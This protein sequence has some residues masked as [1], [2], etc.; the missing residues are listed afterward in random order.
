M[1]KGDFKTI[2]LPGKWT[3]ESV[4]IYAQFLGAGAF[5]KCYKYGESVYSYVKDGKRES[6]YSKQAIAGLRNLKN[7]HIPDIENLNNLENFD[8]QVY[9]SKFYNDL[10]N[11]SIN[12]WNQAKILKK[13]WRNHEIGL[14]ETGYT[15][16]LILINE[17]KNAGINENIINA[18]DEINTA[19]HDYG[20]DYYMEFPTRNLKVD[21]SG[22]LILLDIIFNQRAIR[23]RPKWN[24]S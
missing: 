6:D 7:C 19:C 1:K 20:E 21:E 12:A 2:E 14:H 10:T 23:E 16:N 5:A 8:G 17:F 13:V 9:K 15:D 18:I 4:K 11:K 3:G 22:N 24:R